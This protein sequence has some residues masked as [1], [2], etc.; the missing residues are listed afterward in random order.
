MR[1]DSWTT[2]AHTTLESKKSAIGYEEG[3]YPKSP[4]MQSATLP[5]LA[6]SLYLKKPERIMAFLMVMTVCLPVYAALEYRIRTVLKEQEATFPD[7]KGKRIPNPTARWVFHYFVG[8]H[9][10]YIPE[11]G[12]MMLNL[13]DE[14]Q[15]LL[16]RL[17]KRYAWFYR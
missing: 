6:S 4:H 16:Q 10:L 12:L 7:Q 13:T 9:V 3:A 11:Q 14:H 2:L 17:G 8:M 15:H 5:F 1:D